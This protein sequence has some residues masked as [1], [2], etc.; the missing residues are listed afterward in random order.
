MFIFCLRYRLSQL[1]NCFL[2]YSLFY[3]FLRPASGIELRREI[4]QSKFQGSTIRR[5][6]CFHLCV[7][8]SIDGTEMSLIVSE[9]SPL[10]RTNVNRTNVN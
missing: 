6:G 3:Y 5:D 2:Y 7:V 9:Q 8:E 4:Q 10:N 1:S